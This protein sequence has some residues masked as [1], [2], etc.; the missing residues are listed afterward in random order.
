[1]QNAKILIAGDELA[2]IQTCKRLL[3]RVGHEVDSAITV[4]EAVSH[5]DRKD[6]DV[7]FFDLKFAGGELL[8]RMKEAYPATIVV[9]I[10]GL[11]S[12]KAADALGYGVYEYLPKPITPEAMFNTLSW[13]LHQRNLRLQAQQN[14]T[15][16]RESEFSELLG[17]SPAMQSL[18]NVIMRVAPTSDAVLLIGEPGTGKRIAA[19]TIHQ[20]SQRRNEPFVEIE[21]DRY[22]SDETSRRIFGYYKPQYDEWI[23]RPGVLDKAG[24]G[25][26]YID[27]IATI[28]TT[29]QEQLVKAIQRRAY[30]PYEGDIAKIAACRFILGTT[31]KPRISAEEEYIIDDLYRKVEVYP[32][33]LPSLAER[34][35]DIPELVQAAMKRYAKRLGKPVERIEDKLLTRLIARPWRENVRELEKCIERMVSVCEDDTL[36]L[37]HYSE[38]MEDQLFLSWDGQVPANAEELKKLKAKLRRD[39][40]RV[41]EREFLIEAL[42]QSNGNVTHAAKTVGMQRRNFQNMMREHGVMGG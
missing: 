36:T 21:C 11:A 16:K 41:V 34:A 24:G 8:E 9:I 28:D 4:Q 12:L 6:Y 23:Y 32:V 35:E 33:Y 26:I 30:L 37:E 19:Q 17:S 29:G 38:A 1:M 42:R 25:T 10:H 7:L 15:D 5:L 31:R 20:A 22:P 2:V 14:E 27:E 13:A 40:V 39:A 18:F 3:T